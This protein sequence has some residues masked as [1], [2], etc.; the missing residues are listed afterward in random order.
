M[1]AFANFRGDD[2]DHDGMSCKMGIVVE[3]KSVTLMPNFMIGV[4]LSHPL[5]LSEHELR[6]KRHESTKRESYQSTT[7]SL[8]SKGTPTLT[9]HSN[10]NITTII[11]LQR[12][13]RRWVT[14]QICHE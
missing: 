8:G 1:R 9:L 12:E 14:L 6:A 10:N 5:K 13:A 4:P 3:K 7:S 11:I 2:E